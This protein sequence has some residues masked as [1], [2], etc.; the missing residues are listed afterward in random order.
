MTRWPTPSR[1]SSRSRRCRSTSRTGCRRSSRRSA[2]LAGQHE[3]SQGNVPTGVTAAAAIN[4]LQEADDTRLG[5]DI[6][7]ME[8]T[9]EDAGKRILQLMARYYSDDSHDPPR[10]DR[11]RRGTSAVQGLRCSTATT[12]SRCRPGSGMPRSKA[13]KQA[14]CRRSSTSPSRTAWSSTSA[15]CASSSRTSRWAASRR[16]MADIDNDEAQ[17][18]REHQSAHLGP[19]PRSRRT[20]TTITS[21]T[22]TAHNDF[23]KG[24]S[25]RAP[26]RRRR[27]CLRRTCPAITR[28]LWRPSASSRW[29]NRSRAAGSRA[30]NHHKEGS[31]GEGTAG[32]DGSGRGA[33]PARRLRAG[34]ARAGRQGPE[35]SSSA[36]RSAAQEAGGVEG[37]GRETPV[38]SSTAPITSRT[39]PPPP[40][41]GRTSTPSPTR[42]SRSPTGTSYVHGRRARGAP[43]GRLRG[44]ST[45]SWGPATASRSS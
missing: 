44:T 3:V 14:P 35:A 11:S 25:L 29:Q 36:R 6:E 21:S 8:K 19:G 28:T 10:R 5:P 1:S 9:L 15:P 34:H 7:D 33:R 24:L 39:T 30:I 18:N 26:T 4:L 20:T 17:V 40:R 13:A 45:T 43:H 31:S 38:A 23:R 27:R 22:S 2:E 32:A 42:T 16:L 41:S 12:T 37:A